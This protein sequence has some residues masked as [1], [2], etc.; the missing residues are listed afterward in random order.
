V[1]KPKEFLILI[2]GD[3]VVQVYQEDS[4]GIES[5]MPFTG[6]P[7]KPLEKIPLIEKK[8]YIDVVKRLDTAGRLLRETH[9]GKA[10]SIDEFIR[11]LEVE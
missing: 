7:R 11:E 1:T 5:T 2:S 3:R 4:N 10:A 9:P 6:S 8:A